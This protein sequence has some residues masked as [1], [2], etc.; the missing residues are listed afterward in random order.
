M[1]KQNIVELYRILEKINI[2]G[3]DIIAQK[4]ILNLIRL[5]K[6]V[7]KDMESAVETAKELQ[8]PEG[9]EEAQKAIE[10][11]NNAINLK[12]EE[13]RL[14]PDEARKYTDIYQQYQN[15]LTSY[16]KDL[17][18][19]EFDAT[20]EKINEADFDKLLENNS[21]ELKANE[22]SILMESFQ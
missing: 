21:K 1:K 4:N 9:F 8:K 2:A 17:E 18:N 22:L 15:N 3:L 10:T 5:F 19:E 12:S 13:G 11:H 6:P 16:V 7:V 14:S 20:V